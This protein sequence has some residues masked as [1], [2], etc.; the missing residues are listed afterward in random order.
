[1][2][3]SL[4]GN[5]KTNKVCDDPSLLTSG[6]K[7]IDDMSAGPDALV[8]IKRTE[9]QYLL[10]YRSMKTACHELC[11]VFG[12]THCPYFE[13][14]MNGSNL[15]N[16]ADAKPFLLCPICLRKLDA[17]F[18][19]QEAIPIRYKKMVQSIEK[20]GNPMFNREKT[21]LIQILDDLAD[22]KII[23]KFPHTH[24]EEKLVEVGAQRQKTKMSFRSCL[25]P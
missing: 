23:E 1:M 15:L 16:E 22:N 4:V 14:L 3:E 17:Y 12:M 7:S 13:C 18:N 10:E 21:T 25:C 24:E 19:L 5:L 9:L 11:H 6:N 2:F 8:D 20:S